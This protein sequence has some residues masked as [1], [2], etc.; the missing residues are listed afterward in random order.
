MEITNFYEKILGIELPW[1]ITEAKIESSDKSVHV[2]LSHESGSKF[3]CKH[4]KELCSVHDHGKLRTWRHLD[5][6]DHYTYLHA[7]VPRVKCSEHGV[8]TIA[9]SWSRA[10]SRFTLQFESFIIDTLQSNQVRSRSALQLRVSEEQLKRIQ[11]Q[12]VERGMSSRKRFKNNPFCIV[13]HVCIDE[14]SLFTGHHYVSIL[15]NG[16]TGVV[17]EVVEH[18]T[19]EAAQNAFTQLGEYIDLQGI[20]VVT[21]DMWKAFQNATKICVPKADIVHDRFH[22]SQYLNNAVDITRRAENKK[23][24][25]QDDERLK[26]TKYLWLKNPD[27]FTEQQQKLHDELMADQELKTV[28]AWEI[29][30]NFKKF[31]DTNTEKEA[32]DF[33]NKWVKSIEAIKN[34]P[35]LKVVKTFKN[36]LQG[37]LDYTKHRVSNAMA[38]CMNMTIQQVKSKARGFKSAKAFRSAI[39]FHLGDLHL[40]P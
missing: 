9:P 2:T 30:E 40:Y 39:L 36:H 1:Q 28:K 24:L 26:G 8:C 38:E 35:L 19:Q 10:N 13:R 15:Y 20:Q 32:T 27:N 18:R 4:C 23:L 11:T 12:A 21:M 34:V 16:Q 33:F 5:T 31:F 22:L 6:C 17:L 14:K 3:P 7:S 25:A 37:L 29:K